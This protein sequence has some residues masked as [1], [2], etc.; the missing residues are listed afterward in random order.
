MWRSC[1]SARPENCIFE[2]PTSG[3]NNMTNEE[4]REV[5]IGELRSGVQNGND[6]I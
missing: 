6:G 3:D 1:Y 2:C 5:G 4:I